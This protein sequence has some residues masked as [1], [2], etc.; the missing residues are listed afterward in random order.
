MSVKIRKPVPSDIEIAQSAELQPIVRVAEALGLGEDDLDLYGRH[1]AKVHLDVL[2]RLKD[3]PL[4]R[5]V[6]VAA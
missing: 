2:D 5:Y 6:D 4:G 1:K 3:A